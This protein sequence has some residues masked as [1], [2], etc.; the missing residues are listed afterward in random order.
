M[1][2]YYTFSKFI[3][4]RNHGMYVYENKYYTARMI[5]L[6]DECMIILYVLLM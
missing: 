3:Y 6:S 1:Y 5:N 2:K 4:K